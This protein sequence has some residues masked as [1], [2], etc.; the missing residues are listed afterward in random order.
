MI[1]CPIC[2]DELDDGYCHECEHCLFD[3][4]E[5]Y[6]ARLAAI[7]QSTER[8]IDNLVVRAAIL[9]DDAKKYKA[10]VL[11]LE[12]NGACRFNCRT[13]KEMFSAGVVWG[14]HNWHKCAQPAPVHLEKMYADWRN[15]H[16]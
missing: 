5:W 3:D 2:S 4:A 1:E 7:V 11:E 6:Y 15:D 16:D 9:N 10:R 8:Q 14:F 13:R 12:E